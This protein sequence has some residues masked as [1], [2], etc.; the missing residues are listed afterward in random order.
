MQSACQLSAQKTKSWPSQTQLPLH[1]IKDQCS[2]INYEPR[3]WVDGMVTANL[4]SSRKSTRRRVLGRP[5]VSLSFDQ[6]TSSERQRPFVPASIWSSAVS[7]R[8]TGDSA[9]DLTPKTASRTSAST[10]TS[11]PSPFRRSAGE[12]L[13]TTDDSRSLTLREEGGEPEHSQHC[14]LGR[15]ESGKLVWQRFATHASLQHVFL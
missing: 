12:A 4:C 1:S 6:F 7:G 3:H 11:F 10:L 8:Q 5:T 9:K 14:G 2:F 13:C 15:G